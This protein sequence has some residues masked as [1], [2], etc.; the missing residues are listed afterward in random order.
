MAIFGGPVL[1]VENTWRSENL[2]VNSTRR[3][4]VTCKFSEPVEFTAAS[5]GPPKMASFAI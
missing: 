4:K 2:H 5:S 3:L 1:A